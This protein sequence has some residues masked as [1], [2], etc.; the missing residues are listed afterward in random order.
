MV[1]ETAGIPRIEVVVVNELT[2]LEPDVPLD[3]LVPL[4]PDVPSAPLNL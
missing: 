2:P 1:D 4:D 3:P